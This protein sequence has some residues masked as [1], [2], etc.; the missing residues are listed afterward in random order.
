MSNGE[1]W[2]AMA[3]RTTRMLAERASRIVH[4]PPE[5][6]GSCQ[7]T[8]TGAVNQVF[9]GEAGFAGAGQSEG[10]GMF[11]HLADRSGAA[12]IDLIHLGP[13]PPMGVTAVGE[14]HAGQQGPEEWFALYSTSDGEELSEVFFAV[15]GEVRLHPLASGHLG[16]QFAFK[17]RSGPTDGS[18]TRLVTV[19]GYFCARPSRERLPLTAGRLSWDW[20]L[21]GLGL[22]EADLDFN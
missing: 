12:A 14:L 21:E 11:L 18:A 2:T 20:D 4:A 8:I 19:A 6:I 5:S 10:P 15:S 7:V 17:A 9:R 16:G 3:A 1:G 22:E 13:L